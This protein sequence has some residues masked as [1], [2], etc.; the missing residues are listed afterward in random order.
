MYSLYPSSGFTVMGAVKCTSYQVWTSSWWWEA[1]SEIGTKPFPTPCWKHCWSNQLLRSNIQSPPALH[2]ALRSTPST[3][4][5]L[6]Y[7]GGTLACPCLTTGTLESGC[8]WASLGNQAGI[9]QG[10]H[11]SGVQGRKHEVELPEWVSCSQRRSFGF[12]ICLLK[13][14]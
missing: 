13:N 2:P 9:E 11:S 6:S 5:Q 14:F 3:L 7:R 1:S 8:V 12:T 10:N 4:L